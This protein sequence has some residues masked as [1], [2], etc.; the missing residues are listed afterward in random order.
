MRTVLVL[1][2]LGLLGLPL[3]C[4]RAAQVIEDAK[5]SAS[6]GQRE[7]GREVEVEAGKPFEIVLGSPR[8]V[9]S[10]HRYEWASEPVIEG[11]GIELERFEQR[12]PPNDVDG[13]S[14]GYHY[15]FRAGA[16]GEATISIAIASRGDEAPIDPYQLRVRIRP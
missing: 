2:L 12:P 3:A 14:L 9:A 10:E 16:E 1:A 13:G 5:L 6:F 4:T 15:R 11:S 8:G 7:H